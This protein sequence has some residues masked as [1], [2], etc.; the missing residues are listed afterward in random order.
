MSLREIANESSYGFFNHFRILPSYKKIMARYG[1]AV[2]RQPEGD[3]KV[4]SGAGGEALSKLTAKEVDS[5]GSIRMDLR[6]LKGFMGFLHQPV[7]T[8]LAKDKRKLGHNITRFMTTG[9]LEIPEYVDEGLESAASL[10]CHEKG[11]RKMKE[12]DIWNN[13]PEFWHSDQSPQTVSSIPGTSYDPER[14]FVFQVHESV[15]TPAENL[16]SSQKQVASFFWETINAASNNRYADKDVSEVVLSTS[17]LKAFYHIL[18]EHSDLG[19]ICKA[20]QIEEKAAARLEKIKSDSESLSADPRFQ[21]ALATKNYTLSPAQKMDSLAYGASA[22]TPFITSKT[23]YD[24]WR[25]SHYIEKAIELS[26]PTEAIAEEY[27]VLGA[28]LEKF[29]DAQNNGQE[30]SHADL[31][32]LSNN[33][34]PLFAFAE[35]LSGCLNAGAENKKVLKH[36][37]PSELDR[38]K[39][40]METVSGAFKQASVNGVTTNNLDGNYEEILVSIGNAL[41]QNGNMGKQQLVGYYEMMKGFWQGVGH[42]AFDSPAVF[43]LVV[44]LVGYAYYIK[45]GIDP[46]ITQQIADTGM[47]QVFG[48][49][50]MWGDA[51]SS[52]VD[53]GGL[54]DVPKAE[55]EAER[56]AGQQI[57]DSAISSG[58]VDDCILSVDCH[59]NYLLPKPMLDLMG[60][61]ANA[62]LSFRHYVGSDIIAS[63]ANTV[64][65]MVPATMEGI[66]NFVGLPVEYNLEFRNT[67]QAFTERGGLMFV[68]ANMFQDASH[69]SMV[70][71]GI[72]RVAKNGM[73]AFKQMGGLSAEFIN[74]FRRILLAGSDTLTKYPLRLSSA[75]L[76]GVSA[77]GMPGVTAASHYLNAKA[78]NKIKAIESRKTQDVNLIQ[79][80]MQSVGGAAGSIVLE[81]ENSAK[82]SGNTQNIVAT[83]IK[84]NIGWYGLGRKTVSIDDQNIDHLESAINEFALNLYY[85]SNHIGIE[86]ERY[87]EFLKERVENIE[88][89]LQEY[90]AKKGADQKANQNLRRVL[91]GD[92]QHVMG[93]ELKYNGCDKIYS[94]LFPDANSHVEELK[95]KPFY[96]RFL[97]KLFTES[98]LV[99]DERRRNV[100]ARHAAK[101][102]GRFKRVEFREEFG[103]KARHEKNRYADLQEKG[104]VPSLKKAWGAV[105]AGYNT[106]K[107]RLAQGMSYIWDGVVFTAREGIQEPFCQMPMKKRFAGAAAILTTGALS[108]EMA[109]IDHSLVEAFSSAGGATLGTL[110][111]LLIGGGLNIPQDLALHTAAVGFSAACVGVPYY[112]AVQRGIKPAS[113]AL[114]EMTKRKPAEAAFT[115]PEL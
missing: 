50:N 59:Y 28:V 112:F 85:S 16:G 99:L 47:T 58:E 61:S 21:I 79:T 101:K 77:L 115:K 40:Q 31:Q 46:Q 94:S 44:G 102:E 83:D 15:R 87:L 30:P 81:P 111:T 19:A 25:H 39:S 56:I 7:S 10:K 37:D 24:V 8:S 32:A 80:A 110:S 55:F 103:R 5:D 105:A 42:S 29:K 36:I 71:Y 20:A 109:G 54:V 38:F 60:E 97:R 63:N 86:S 104:V 57:I 45:Y 41:G 27:A 92:L 88:T 100:L 6:E 14:G 22:L 65:N 106:G 52:G 68:D 62:Y 90:K 74:P 34:R 17:E 48:S 23:N 35:D 69:A 96:K 75:A 1:L 12:T 26:N 43:G 66:H 49:S 13:E 98:P 76:S 64:V 72:S 33:F 78:Q 95:K 91:N 107:Y 53:G 70:G 89:V 4:T 108:A 82:P 113:A 84:L 51:V 2:E 9:L 3:F 18:E 114:R 67:A 73:G 93:A 11:E